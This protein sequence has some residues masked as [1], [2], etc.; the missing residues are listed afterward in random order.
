[1]K[2]CEITCFFVFFCT[3]SVH[4]N[5]L[6][7]ISFYKVHYQNSIE[8]A[9][10]NLVVYKITPLFGPGFPTFSHPQS[11]SETQTMHAPGSGLVACVRDSGTHPEQTILRDSVT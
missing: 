1:M 5:S 3:P 4:K 7:F 2:H 9:L 6:R 11:T 8:F 10:A